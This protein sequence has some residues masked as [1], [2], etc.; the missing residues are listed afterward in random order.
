AVTDECKEKIEREYKRYLEPLS[1]EQSYPFERT[2]F[3][4][5]C[6]T[7]KKPGLKGVHWKSE[8]PPKQP[9][10]QPYPPR[11]DSTLIPE[12]LSILYVLLVHDHPE[13]VKRLLNSLDEPMH[14]FVIHVD[15]KSDSTYQSL[16][17]FAG[18]R[19]NVHV[20]VDR[21][22]GVWGGFS[23]V[24]ATLLG[25]KYAFDHDLSFDFAIDMSGQSYPIK[26][27]EVIRKTLAGDSNKIYMDIRADPNV[28]APELWHHY[29]ECDNR[30]HRITRMATPR[31]MHLF[32]GSQW[33]ILPRHAVQW[34]L[35]DSLPREFIEYAKHIMVADEHYFTTLI[36]NS[37][38]C[39][40]QVGKNL[41]Y[42]VFGEWEQELLSRNGEKDVRKCNQPDP[43]HCGRS[44]T[45]LTKQ[46]LRSVKASRSL[47]A[48]KF[49]PAN[50]TSMEFVDLVD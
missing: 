11:S 26:S 25:L 2:T 6:P 44:P 29:V 32:M 34:L 18:D 8:G 9:P 19:Q 13:F 33:F 30:G 3:W 1:L 7:V 41:N 15:K 49:D 39:A 48:R 50:S 4:P 5:Q 42:L 12:N 22:N 31:G 21:V 14:H 17:E 10:T 40:D 23:L 35:T 38:Y 16:V 46:F 28:P 27:N 43:Q 45:T 36:K 37:P 24:N 20:L 47:F